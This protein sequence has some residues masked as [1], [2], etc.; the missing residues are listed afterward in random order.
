MSPVN[1]S[2][3]LLLRRAGEIAFITIAAVLIE[4]CSSS[5]SDDTAPITDPET[6][7]ARFSNAS[8]LQETGGETTDIVVLD[9]NQDGHLDLAVSAAEEISLLLGDGAGGLTRSSN[10]VQ[11]AYA[12]HMVAADYNGDGFVDIA[13]TQGTDTK[14]FADAVCG[15]SIGVVVLLNDGNTEPTFTHASCVVLGAEPLSATT[16]DINDDG[17]VDLVVARNGDNTSSLAVFLGSGDGAFS[18]AIPIATVSALSSSELDT[19][20]LNNDGFVDL[21]TGDGHIL[22]GVGNIR[23][24][25]AADIEG[26]KLAIGDLNKDGKF[27]IVSAQDDT[28]RIYHGNG[29]GTFELIQTLAGEPVDDLI[30][31]DFNHDQFPDVAVASDNKVKIFAG[32]A[33]STLG[34][35][36]TVDTGNATS[37]LAVGDLNSDG[38]PD[39]VIP[40]KEPRAEGSLLINQTPIDAN[41]DRTPPEILLTAPVFARGVIAPELQALLKCEQPN[42][43]LA[44]IITFSPTRDVNDPALRTFLESRSATH[45]VL[46]PIIDSIAAHVPAS[47]IADLANIR[48]IENIR[49]DAAIPLPQ[50]LLS[51][52][53]DSACPGS[54]RELTVMVTNTVAL[55]ADASDNVGVARVEFYFDGGNL[56]GVSAGP[57]V[58][59]V[60]WN[61]K[62][63]ADGSHTITAVAFDAAGN[64]TTS[65]PATV[66]VNNAR[67]D[68]TSVAPAGDIA[69]GQTFLYAVTA[70]GAPPLNYDLAVFP[71]GMSIDSDTGEIRWTPQAG[72][73]GIHSA[74]VQ[75]SNAVGAAT[76]EFTVRVGDHTPPNI[77]SGLR[78]DKITVDSVTLVWNAPGDNVGVA[79]Y[80]VYEY[81]N[82][83][84]LY[85]EWRLRADTVAT[86]STTITGLESGSIHRYAV[87]ALDSNSNESNRSAILEIKTQR[88]PTAFHPVG[89][90]DGPVIAVAGQEFSYVVDAIGEPRPSFALVAG[91][92]GMTVDAATGVVRWTPQA[93]GVVNVTVRASNML[94]FDDHEFTISVSAQG[95]D[96]IPPQATNVLTCSNVTPAGCD[97]EWAPATD[98]VGIAGYR[99]KAQRIGRGNSLFTVAESAGTATTFTITTLQADTSYHVWVAAF[100]A[101]G[102]EGS[103]S[104][105]VPVFIRTTSAGP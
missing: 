67:P 13:V 8:P 24:S 60:G 22:L 63:V 45:I 46:L 15:E 58:F 88:A 98:N 25:S 76:Q 26:G 104:G 84:P 6:P 27:D 70:T 73:E 83:N 51:R 103:I 20:D 96:L 56:I 19:A 31:G 37:Q 59:T 64:Q 82:V 41:V 53:V 79:S 54:E 95:T 80:R 105:Q 47:A 23:F 32:G 10:V 100:D 86:L 75:V 61:T 62:T 55:V 9:F 29:D 87:S 43:V 21:V 33:T 81:V 16:G 66:V 85:S 17:F 93:P 71:S 12:R 1:S 94:G 30:I 11:V 90:T 49:L 50:I 5:S 91:P 39:L 52:S 35:P 38:R 7:S 99:I 44:I 74:S 92:A 42:K 28:I 2:V 48:D 40:A 18:D 4:S 65:E 68:I 57:E 102:N 72:Q 101:A 69:T 77:P 78:A 34:A 3:K 36:Q 89:G 14:A 97:L